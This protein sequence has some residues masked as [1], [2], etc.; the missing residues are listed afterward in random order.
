M[1]VVGSYEMD[2]A[3]CF[4]IGDQLLIARGPIRTIRA[5]NRTISPINRLLIG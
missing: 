4:Q 2:A 3:Q 1:D 5:I